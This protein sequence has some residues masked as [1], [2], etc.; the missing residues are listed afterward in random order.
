MK[1]LKFNQATIELK[2]PESMTDE[3]CSSLWVYQ[4]EDGQ[5]ISLWTASIFERIKFLFHGHIWI[6]I[7]SGKKQPPIWLDC[8]KDAF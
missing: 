4:S 6:G 5:C 7:L 2:K 3:E 1:P 8:S